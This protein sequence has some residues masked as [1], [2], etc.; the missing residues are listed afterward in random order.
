MNN[1]SIWYGFL[2]AGE[3]S[4]P[5]VRD[6][7]L[8]TDNAK[9]VYLYN[10]TR[11]IFLEYALEIVEPKLRTL[12]PGD[13]SRQEL[14]NAFMAAR[15]TFNPGKAVNNLKCV[16]PATAATAVAVADIEDEIELDM[17]DWDDDDFPDDDD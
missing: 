4:S 10:F 12:K 7:S 3:K 8:E 1:D 11:G 16:A 15:K 6:L 14:E 17:D 2:E 9:T 13:V 5:V